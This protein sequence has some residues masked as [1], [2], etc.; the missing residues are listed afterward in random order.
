[1]RSNQERYLAANSP[2]IALERGMGRLRP[3]RRRTEPSVSPSPLSRRRSGP[4]SPAYIGPPSVSIP[5]KRAI[6]ATLILASAFLILTVFAARSW[7]WETRRISSSPRSKHP[8]ELSYL[9]TASSHGHRHKL[10]SHHPLP[11]YPQHAVYAPANSNTNIASSHA[12]SYHPSPQE[13]YLAY[14]PHSGFHNQRVSFENALI[15]ARM[16]NRTLIVPPI[17]LGLFL[18]FAPF[19]K[20]FRYVALSTKAGLDH[21]PRTAKLAFFVPQECL[22]YDEYTMV[23]WSALVNLHHIAHLVRVVERWDPSSAFLSHFLNISSNEVAYV[24]DTRPYQLQIYDDGSNPRPLNPKY[25][26]RLNVEDLKEEYG[27]YRLLH[28]GSIFGS[29]RFRLTGDENLETRKL[30]RESMVYQNSVLIGI[31]DSISRSEELGLFEIGSGD[32]SANYWAVHLRLGDG[33]FQKKREKNIR[34]LWWSL[35]AGPMNLGLDDVTALESNILGVSRDS[36]EPP[37]ATLIGIETARGQFIDFSNSSY[38]KAQAPNPSSRSTNKTSNCRGPLYTQPH[39]VN[40]NNPV[41]I[42]TDARNPRDHPSLQIFVRTL[43]CL[44]F[45][46]DFTAPVPGPLPA[47]SPLASFLSVFNPFD[48]K[49]IHIPFLRSNERLVSPL[50]AKKDYLLPL[51]AILNPDDQLPLEKFLLPFIDSMVAA[52]AKEVLGTPHST[53]SRFTVDVLHQV[54]VGREIMQRGR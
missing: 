15:L 16:L 30:V 35:L 8:Q 11:K 9:P 39:L 37:D 2:S 45:L 40:L 13:Q 46:S 44:F 38:W 51:H 26:E 6:Y 33:I 48:V 47:P 31:A 19:D 18:R 34:L 49:G 3:P 24:K 36:I 29:S 41:Y 14:L 43:P 52:R 1:M 5:R 12:V 22:G 25:A 10:H 32:T 42:A 17:R 4:R 54:H 28:I 7:R 50:S 21:C 20:L 27:D 23:P 53:F